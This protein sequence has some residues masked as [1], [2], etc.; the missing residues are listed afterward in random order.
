MAAGMTLLIG[1]L[2]LWL[3]LTGKLKAMWDT[4]TA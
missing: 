1:I 3:V 4:L 2:L